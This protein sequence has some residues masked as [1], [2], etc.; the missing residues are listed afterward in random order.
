M[1][2][3]I[4]LI[5]IIFHTTL[6]E[7]NFF[8][9]LFESLSHENRQSE[10]VSVQEEQPKSEDIIYEHKSI[11][12][13]DDEEIEIQNQTEREKMIYLSYEFYP[14][15]VYVKQ[16]F[17]IT[18]KAIVI[19]ENINRLKLEYI[20]GK[21]YK[22]INQNPK[23]EK[24]AD[25]S[26]VCNIYFKLQSNSSKLPAIKI[27]ALGSG[28]KS[29]T[30]IIKPKELKLI[31]LKK[32][33]L[34]SGVMAKDL[35]V[36]SHKEKRYDDKNILV[37][38]DLN[39]T[40]SNLEDFHLSFVQ[41]EALDSFKDHLMYQQVY[42]VCIVPN[43]QKEFKFKYFD[44]DSNR[45]TRISFPIIMADLTLSTQLGLNPKKSKLYIY[46]LIFLFGLAIIFLLIYLK[47]KSKFS[48]FIA[49]LIAVFTLFTKVITPTLNL[50]KDT[51]IRILPTHNSTIFFKTS[52]PT[53]V[54][55]LLKKEGYSK[56]LLP[57]GKIGWIKDDDLQ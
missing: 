28:T 45:F 19:D 24:I 17:F 34:F 57:S 47:S 48:L 37:L 8:S 11:F 53:E 9:D 2:N 6:L 52:K 22:V 29:Y 41:K 39:A 44:L 16:H 42:Y 12:S 31:E 40:M 30:Q 43:Y 54:K 3:L 46:E 33:E 49:L 18:L 7:A 56:V 4:F 51:K 5:A 15:K 50:P 23:W 32:S 14:K 20:G 13:N 21:N 25:K 26:F 1:R 36:V 35:K 27:T 55:V 38:M 10:D